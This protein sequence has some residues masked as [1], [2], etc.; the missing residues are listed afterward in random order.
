MAQ[1]I[2]GAKW[3][4]LGTKWLLVTLKVVMISLSH[5]G[6]KTLRFPRRSKVVVVVAPPREL[7]LMGQEP[8]RFLAPSSDAGRLGGSLC[9]RAGD[10]PVR[11]IGI[12]LWQTHAW[13]KTLT[14]A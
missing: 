7:D 14:W 13:T 8:S 6:R 5:S 3:T 9:A 1:K 4:R 10:V 11:R 2:S 12:S